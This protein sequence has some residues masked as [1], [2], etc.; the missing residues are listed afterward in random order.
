MLHLDCNHAPS[1]QT[2]PVPTPEPPSP[3]P[4]PRPPTPAPTPV[5]TRLQWAR[6]DGMIET[7]G[8]PV[9][10]FPSTCGR[11]GGW[12][13]ED[14]W[15]QTLDDFRAI[16]AD[17][18]REHECTTISDAAESWAPGFENSPFPG[19]TPTCFWRHSPSPI[20][21]ERCLIRGSP[22]GHRFCPCAVP[23]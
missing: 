8:P 14:V 20:K 13:V 21:P 1:P 9:E 5:P 7:C 17:I 12:C 23:I 4:T 2:T 15:P 22:F 16:L 19:S 3:A 10:G 11:L 18:P 6:S